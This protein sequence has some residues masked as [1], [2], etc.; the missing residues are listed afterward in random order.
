MDSVS[1]QTGQ[2]LYQSRKSL[3]SPVEAPTCLA[4]WD[5]NMLKGWAWPWLP[6][7]CS[8]KTSGQEGGAAMPQ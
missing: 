3:S 5:P 2:G 7:S 8:D 6:C 4:P 1:A